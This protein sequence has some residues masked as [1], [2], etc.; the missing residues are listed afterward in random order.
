MVITKRYSILSGGTVNNVFTQKTE[1]DFIKDMDERYGSGNYQILEIEE[2]PL[3]K[4]AM[5]ATLTNHADDNSTT[6]I[7]GVRSVDRFTGSDGRTST[8]I[9]TDKLECFVFDM[10]HRSIQVTEEGA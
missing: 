4:Q 2:I 6:T 9:L 8:R 1:R 3:S 5:K 10:T 7:H